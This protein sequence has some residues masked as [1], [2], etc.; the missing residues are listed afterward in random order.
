MF[1]PLVAAAGKATSPITVAAMA[2][3][4]GR[5]S[6]RLAVGMRMDS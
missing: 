5:W 2:V 3:S 1:M 6:K 4:M